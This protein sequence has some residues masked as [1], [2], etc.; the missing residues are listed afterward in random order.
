MLPLETVLLGALLA[1]PDVA[2]LIGTRAYWQRLPRDPTFPAVTFQMI[3]RV[4]DQTTGIAQARV[5]YTCIAESPAAADALASAV[6]C[7]LHGYHVV[8][9]ELR[10]EYSR[11]VGQT[12]DHDVTTG[13]SWAPVDVLVTYLEV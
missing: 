8:T 10:I 6:R 1:N 11:Y 5:Q 12:E 3:S 13:L 4:Q 9:D 7:A 2:A